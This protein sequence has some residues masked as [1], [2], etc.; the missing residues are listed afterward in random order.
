METLRQDLAFAVRMLRKSP[1]FAIVAIGAIA[2]GTAAVTTIYSVINVV[3]LQSSP[4]VGHPDKLVTVQRSNIRGGGFS[5]MS[6]PLY[7]DLR[8][9]S[10]T[11]AGLAAFTEVRADV[12]LGASDAREAVGGLIVTGNYFDVLEVKPA[13][14]R[15]FLPEEDGTPLSHPVAVISHR[16]WVDR[17][18]S[19]PGVLGQ[20]IQIQAHPYR[21]IGVAPDGFNGTTAF[22]RHDTYVPM[23]MLAAVRH[24][25]VDMLESRASRWLTVI[26]RTA[27]GISQP[28]A[29]GELAAIADR[30]E[31]AA[32][33]TE[34]AHIR[35]A[36]LRPIPANGVGVIALFMAV[37]MTVSALVLVIAST[38]VASMLLARG[39][40]RRKEF[41]VRLAIGA[42]RSRLIRMLLTE[43]VVLFL[44][45]G[46]AGV[47][48]TAWITRAAAG[49]SI[50]VDVPVDIS[51]PV[52]GRVLAFSL[53]IS[54]VTGI[55]FG[56]IPALRSSRR[57]LSTALRG[58][59]AGSGSRR[60]R[61]R[62]VFVIAQLAMSVLLLVCAGLFVRAFQKGRL[63]NPGFTIDNV[64]VAPLALANAGYDTTRAR[65]YYDELAARIAANPAV[66]AVSYANMVPLNGSGRATQIDIPGVQPPPH[67]AHTVI[68]FETV[69]RTHFTVL[70]L[71]LVRGRYFGTEDTPTSGRVAIVT[72]RFA[73]DYFH[74]VDAAI[75]KTFTLDKQAYTVV[76]VVGDARMQSVSDNVAPFMFLL[77]VQDANPDLTLFV[78]V[79]NASAIP[80]V[81]AAIAAEVRALDPGV[82]RPKVETLVDASAIDLLPQRVA[83]GVTALLGAVGLL[84]AALGLY[85]V[86]AYGVSQR[87]REISIRMALGAQPAD[88]LRMVLGDGTRLVAIGTAIGM[89][90]AVAGSRVLSTFLFGVSP[91]DPL[92]LGAVPAVLALVALVAC[93]IPARRAARVGVAEGLRADG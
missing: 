7:R 81:S 75:G 24:S 78:R 23:A 38:N 62:N 28:V 33:Q 64:L 83:A 3:L 20:T 26:G 87:T 61:T 92:T 25:G 48:L 54:F 37:L 60:E 14:G 70:R 18:A 29:Q 56:L 65:A 35:V 42:N 58:D 88:M 72:R 12:G 71:P 82:T 21:I 44:L 2:I 4:G 89:V 69:S 52:N 31:K 13:L 5:V 93:W 6:Y 16:F 53:L 36:T 27:P 68:P 74:S 40:A 10:R 8:N 1:L 79:R 55:L 73:E 41:V 66:E 9:E 50:N 57:D 51:F 80:D 84:L 15:F 49:M 45:G 90:I 17:F 32:G 85:G 76:G 30:S 46:T 34:A 91:V 77:D 67:Q 86:I 11:L 22:V 19:S 43:S 59:S 47:L 39:V 63:V